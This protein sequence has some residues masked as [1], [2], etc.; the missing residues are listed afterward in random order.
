MSRSSNPS[1]VQG[2]RVVTLSVSVRTIPC[3]SHPEWAYCMTVYLGAFPDRSPA[4]FVVKKILSLLWEAGQAGFPKS[5][6]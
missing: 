5:E 2:V 6:G 3:F 4:D 1:D